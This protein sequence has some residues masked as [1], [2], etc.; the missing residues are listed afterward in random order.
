VILPN[1]DFLRAAEA[2][3]L[4]NFT[5]LDTEPGSPHYLDGLDLYAAQ[6][7]YPPE[8]TVRLGSNVT[9]ALFPASLVGWKLNYNSVPNPQQKGSFI[10]SLTIQKLPPPV[11]MDVE[12]SF[13]QLSLSSSDV[14]DA[15]SV[16]T[17]G[18][19]S[20]INSGEKIEESDDEYV[21]IQ[22]HTL[23]Q[24]LV[25]TRGSVAME[26][27]NGRK[28]PEESVCLITDSKP[29]QVCKAIEMLPGQKSLERSRELIMIEKGIYIPRV[30][31]LN[32]S[33]KNAA[34]FLRRDKAGGSEFA[35]VLEGWSY[36]LG[37]RDGI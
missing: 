15:V 31:A 12:Q 1:E 17:E 7:E 21:M 24:R 23:H 4:H 18:S 26:R 30:E 22:P 36:V 29:E 10:M 27:G 2:L 14:N 19:T 20:T 8:I 32:E 25:E 34:D 16:A 35:N 28:S 11:E 37:G 6:Y 9:I 33:F 3:R 13:V 5:A